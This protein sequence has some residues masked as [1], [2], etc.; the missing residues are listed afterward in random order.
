MTYDCI[1]YIFYCFKTVG[2]IFRHLNI[3]LLIGVHCTVIAQVSVFYTQNE[4]IQSAKVHLCDHFDFTGNFQIAI[5][6]V[7]ADTFCFVVLNINQFRYSFK[8]RNN[9]NGFLTAH[10]D[11]LKANNI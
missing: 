8:E 4:G 10:K 11:D 7:I 6:Y 1:L 2:M 9:K 5:F 3:Y